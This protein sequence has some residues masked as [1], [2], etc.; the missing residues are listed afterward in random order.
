MRKNRADLDRF[1]T[2]R[3]EIIVHLITDVS[4]GSPG[5]IISRDEPLAGD[6]E[7]SGTRTGMGTLG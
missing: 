5:F 1:Q 2:V 7:K 4:S 6:Y 3:D